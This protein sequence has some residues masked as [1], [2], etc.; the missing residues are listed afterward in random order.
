MPIMF[1]KIVR[2]GPIHLN[3]GDHGFSSWSIKLG[4]WS[5]N[6]RT[7]AQRVDLPGPVSWR[8]KRRAS[9]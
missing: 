5:W 3:F 7:R 9:N 8:S 2:L 1:R 6:S 4:K